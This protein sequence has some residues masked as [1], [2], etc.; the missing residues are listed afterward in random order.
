MKPKSNSVLERKDS[1][2]NVLLPNALATR[3][4]DIELELQSGTITKEQILEL[5]GL[6]S[7][8]PLLTSGSHGVLRGAQR[9]QV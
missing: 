7:V 4:L 1:G 2:S 5:L 6:Y 3:I 8:N 9:R